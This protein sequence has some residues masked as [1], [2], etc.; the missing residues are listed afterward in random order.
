M[1]KRRGSAILTDHVQGTR[2]WDE[3]MSAHARCRQTM[4]SQ[5]ITGIFEENEAC[6][7]LH[8]PVLF[9]ILRSRISVRS[10]WRRHLRAGEC[11]ARVAPRRFWK[12][13][14]QPLVRTN[15]LNCEKTALRTVVIDLTPMLPGGTNGGAKGFV[16]ELV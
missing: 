7:G 1:C 2:T 11:P 3:N 5:S 8:Q 13:R 9:R 10:P 6:T 15:V 14:R 4:S 12:A 16:Q